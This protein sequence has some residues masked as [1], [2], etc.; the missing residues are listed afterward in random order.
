MQAWPAV[1]PMPIALL[2]GATGL[3]GGELCRLLVAHGWGVI[4]LV[5]S[6]AP[7]LG[8]DGRSISSAVYVGL[9]PSQGEV[10]RLIGDI[11]QLQCGLDATTV[12]QLETRVDI[13]IHCAASTAFNATDAYYQQTNIDGTAQV[14]SLGGNKPFLHVS[15]AYVCGERDGPIAE[16]ACARGTLFANGY[17]RS[18]AAAE[19]LVAQ[20]SRPWLITRPS[21]VVGNV[22]NGQ[23]RRFDSIYGTFKIL[24]EG[25]IKAI[26]AT[27]NASLNLV[28]IDF[29]ADALAKLAV[30][31][32]NF[33]CEFVHICANRSLSLTALF[34]AISSLPALKAPVRVEPNDF[35]MNRLSKFEN[36][37]FE[38]VLK[39]YLPYFR[40]S[41]EFATGNIKRLTGIQCPA[42]DQE[43]LR[44]LIG[45]AIMT[46]FVRSASA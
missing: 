16:L 23:I 31:K 45:Y 8:N 29:V 3:I 33:S 11:G 25:R 38:R 5:R 35:N 14:L 15:T 1:D 46:G 41:P 6:N 20:S 34:E 40:R 13:V 44:K 27:V 19:A 37:L 4:G 43:T 7:I 26:P 9:P 39:Y 22:S 21:I 18:K 17:E 30:G 2:T 28:P 42:I 32:D 36:I 10:L 12:R 24:A